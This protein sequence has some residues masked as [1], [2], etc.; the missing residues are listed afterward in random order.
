MILNGNWKDLDKLEYDISIKNEAI[1]KQAIKEE[2][3]RISKNE[4]QIDSSQSKES[5]LIKDPDTESTEELSSHRKMEPKTIY[6]RLKKDLKNDFNG[7]PFNVFWLLKKFN[8]E[9][10]TN[11][12]ESRSKEGANSSNKN[13]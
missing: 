9:F 6:M 5:F 8:T 3:H 13:E 7:K 4:D 11:R 2:Y 10:Q 12:Q 1:I